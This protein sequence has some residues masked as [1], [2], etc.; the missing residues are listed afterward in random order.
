MEYIEIKGMKFHS[1]I[2]HYDEEK[3]IGNKFNIDLKIKTDCKK[4]GTSDNLNDALDYVNVYSVVKT[5][6]NKKCNLVENVV[7]R[8]KS[9]IFKKFEQ[10]EHLELKITKLSPKIGGMVDEVSVIVEEWRK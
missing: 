7:A 6:M 10:V 1:Y 8:V 3:Q 2:G 5:E 9:V 4:A